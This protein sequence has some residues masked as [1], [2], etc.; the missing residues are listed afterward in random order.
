MCKYK[1]KLP[2]P[3][4]LRS[5]LGS[6]PEPAAECTRVVVARDEVFLNDFAREGMKRNAETFERMDV[7]VL[8][9]FQLRL[10]GGLRQSGKIVLGRAV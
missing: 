9:P 8:R 3:K 5:F 4:E 6:P 10:A 7:H 1:P 2:V